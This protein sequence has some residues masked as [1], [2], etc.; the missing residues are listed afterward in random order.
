M[1]GAGDSEDES[2]RESGDETTGS[3][4]RSLAASY[5][6]LSFRRHAA[7][8]RIL[9]VD[10]EPAVREAV[11]RALRLQGYETELAADGAEALDALA[12]GR[13]TRSCSTC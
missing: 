10:D 8:V 3:H 5:R 7:R 12:A 1:G 2:E 11:D 4:G 13:P 9:V 6:A